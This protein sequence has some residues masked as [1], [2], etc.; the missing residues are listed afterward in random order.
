MERP[1]EKLKTVGHRLRWICGV[2]ALSLAIAVPAIVGGAYFWATERIPGYRA[3]LQSTLSSDLGLQVRIGS[4]GIS[5]K[6]MQPHLLIRNVEM[7]TGAGKRV[8]RLQSVSASVSW[9]RLL[10]GAVKPE[11]IELVGLHLYL[12][13]ETVRRLFAAGFS[14]EETDFSSSWLPLFWRL[15]RID[16]RQGV[17]SVGSRH[18]SA[19]FP[20][21]F[22]TTAQAVKVNRGIRI[23]VIIMPPPGMAGAIHLHLRIDGDPSKPE[24]LSGLWTASAA[25]LRELPLLAAKYPGS[26]L[27]FHKGEVLMTGIFKDGRVIRSTFRI[28]ANSIKGLRSGKFFASADKFEFAAHMAGSGSSWNLEKMLVEAT[29]AHGRWSASASGSC[30]P[31]TGNTKRCVVDVNHL[32]LTDVIP[33]LRLWPG[34]TSIL[35]ALPNLHGDLDRLR[36]TADLEKGVLLRW[37]ANALLHDAGW[38]V[39]GAIP[40]VAG[41]SGTVHEGPSGG[42]LVLAGPAPTFFV[43]SRFAVPLKFSLLSGTLRWFR[44]EQRWNLNMPDLTWAIRQMQGDGQV[45]LTFPIGR[46]DRLGEARLDLNL[47]FTD[48][49]IARLKPMLPLQWGKGLRNWLRQGVV[50]ARLVAGTAS[51]D[52]LLRQFPF[53]D[54]ASGRFIMD[55]QLDGGIL[56][57][58]A[59]WPSARHL[60]VNLLFRGNGL[61]I[62][63]GQGVVDTVK[64]RQLKGGVSDF[65]DEHAAVTLSAS[66]NANKFYTLLLQSPMRSRLSGLLDRTTVNGPLSAGLKVTI[67]LHHGSEVTTNGSVQLKGV[68][69]QVQGLQLPLTH[70]LGR[71]DFNDSSVRSAGLQ[72][73]AGTTMLRGSIA[74]EPD[75]PAGVLLLRATLNAAHPEG[76]AATLIPHW[77]SLRLRGASVWRARLPFSGKDA[78]RF[79][80]QSDLVGT[81]IALPPP[82]GKTA[83]DRLPT[84]I[85]FAA[86]TPGK[87]EQLTITTSAFSLAAWLTSSGSNIGANGMRIDRLGLRLGPG[88]PPSSRKNEIRVSGV[89]PKLELMR[90]ASLLQSLSAVHQSSKSV[91]S[92]FAAVPAVN[93]NVRVGEMSVGRFRLRPIQVRAQIN[94]SKLRMR[95]TGLGA[96][97]V[98]HWGSKRDILYGR[99]AY[100]SALPVKLGASAPASGRPRVITAKKPVRAA[101]QPIDPERM[102]TLDLAFDK[103]RIGSLQFGQ[104]RILT[105]RTAQG[106]KIQALTISGGGDVK[107]HATGKWLRSTRGSYAAAIFSLHV[108]HLERVLK[109]FGYVPNVTASSANIS[110][111]LVWPSTKSGIALAYAEGVVHLDINN[112]VLKAV[113]P[114]AERVLG[115]LNLYALPR[116]L[117]FNFKDLDHKGLAF[118]HIGGS[119]H[120]GHGEATTSDL[121]VIGPA[122]RMTMRGGIG[123]AKRDFNETVTVYPNIS[124]GITLGATLLGGPIA[125]GIALLSQTLFGRQVNSLASFS[126]R[127]TGS[128]DDPILTRVKETAREP[129]GQKGNVLKSSGSSGHE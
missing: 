128:W 104:F 20:W 94:P 87:P 25:D 65:R 101:Q 6:G 108:N 83:T 84:T 68:T 117:M 110:G 48:S 85:A 35:T 5:W 53:G 54:S 33:W 119:F 69:L 46:D 92:D 106:Q 60:A 21:I 49:D 86:A 124:T 79:L 115:L 76:I 82:F 4:L 78:G 1:P 93:V 61:E 121:S 31:L 116:R 7:Q 72:A 14:S 73:V 30:Q 11:S 17:I 102:P 8:L 118:D 77:I 96:D 95:L 56:K 66:G 89:V 45:R 36:A 37:Q 15:K 22:R 62:G 27:E 120:L 70:L 81:T 88:P 42:E 105:K 74:P 109:T 91:I 90:V 44:K 32:T 24:T 2:V 47:K 55:L 29:N 58:A 59:R 13:K 40:G 23:G 3:A 98:F 39:Q 114:G 123:L 113:H 51:Y 43:P 71:I 127:V 19:G 80:L 18:S 63:P 125:G 129:F 75:S 111:D 34:L 103:V 97:G 12:D 9:R 10:L 107:L 16:L 57:Y 38:S 50:Q 126:Y 28:R 64:F 26:A 112:G 99:F 122:L 41:L 52:G 67:R 100:L